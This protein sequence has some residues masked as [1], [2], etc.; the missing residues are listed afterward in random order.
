M[1][2]VHARKKNVLTILNI[3]DIHFYCFISVNMLHDVSYIRVKS[4]C[5]F[6]CFVDRDTFDLSQEWSSLSQRISLSGGFAFIESIS[7][8]RK[9]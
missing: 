6:I 1:L 5:S 2:K 4:F 8:S 7:A 3:L 9:E